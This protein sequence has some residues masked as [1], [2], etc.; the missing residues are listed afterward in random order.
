[1]KKNVDLKVWGLNFSLPEKIQNPARVI[2]RYQDIFRVMTAYGSVN[3]AVSGKLRLSSSS[4]DAFPVPGDWVKVIFNEHRNHA[5]IASVLPRKS[6]ISRKAPGDILGDRVKEQV[7]AA[8]ADIIFLFNALDRDFNPRRMERFLAISMK[9]G[10]FPVIILSKSDLSNRV[11]KQ[12]A[13]MREVSRDVPIITI[14]TLENQGLDEVNQYLNPGQTVAFL[15]SSGVGKSTLLNKLAGHNI[16]DVREVREKD[17]KGRHTTRTRELFLLPNGALVLDTP[18][19]REL[20][21]WNTEDTIEDVFS[22][23]AEISK[24]C[25]FKDCRH[26]NE[27][28]CAVIEAVENGSLDKKRYE[29]YLKL[30]LESAYTGRRSR[31]YDTDNVAKRTGQIKA[32]VRRKHSKK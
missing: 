10:A 4:P 9:S 3:A 5:V 19:M 24:N 16:Q 20:A 21:L 14:S 15:G 6:K 29:S 28:G 22:D 30:S 18:G 32:F 11:S 2:A 1:M 8:N 17:S 26:I 7:I 12:V 25:R 13:L 23:I 31:N 27:P